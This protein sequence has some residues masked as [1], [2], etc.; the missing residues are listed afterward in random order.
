M[1]KFFN[2]LSPRTEAPRL[3]VFLGLCVSVIA[4]MGTSVNHAS[5]T[6][7]ALLV[8]TGLFFIRDWRRGWQ[9]LLPVDRLVLAGFILY[10]LSVFPSWINVDDT[11]E[12]FKILER[13]LRFALIVPLALVLTARRI[14]LM[15]YLYLGAVLC[16]PF[17]LAI[18]L[19]SVYAHPDEPAHG[20]YHHIIFAELA[21]LNIGVM[22]A[23]LA[24]RALPRWQQ[25]VVVLSMLCALSAAVLSQARGAWLSMPVYLLLA[26]LFGLKEKKISLRALGAIAL[27][28]AALLV[29]TP[30]GKVIGSRM[31][32]AR[33]DVVQ[34]YENDVYY[35]SVG[36]RFLM[37]EIGF[38]LWR[39]HPVAGI[40]TGDF[41]DAIMALKAQGKYPRM[42]VH[43]SLHNIF[44]QA[45]VGTGLIGL[46]ALLAFV[47][48]L[49]A[50]AMFDRRY[51]N[52]ETRVTGLI[53]LISMV[54]F[55]L[56]ESWILRLPMVSVYLI[57]MAVIITNRYNTAISHVSAATPA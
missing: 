11:H 27:L 38:D 24:C 23:L 3:Q 48:I 35:T 30:M 43:N 57:Y 42:E 37:W 54:V 34:F 14:S 47:F 12:A 32:E 26:V 13:Y 15:N 40:G 4:I 17:V 39:E 20:A 36:Q 18:A 2:P 5:S 22:L 21:V 33:N 28:V 44:M 31:Q 50:I 16:G 53:V 10:F 49:P 25:V 52:R 41:D 51:C 9:A 1:T 56:S 46:F 29:L 8:L 55:G 19:Y 45:L 6:V 7:F